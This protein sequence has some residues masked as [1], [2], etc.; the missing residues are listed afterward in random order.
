MKYFE[1]FEQVTSLKIVDS[2]FER[3]EGKNTLYVIGRTLAQ[4]YDY[5]Y[6]TAIF[7]EE[8]QN[9]L[10]WTAW[11]KIEASIPV[12]TITPIHA[13]NRLFIFWVQQ[14]E[15]GKDNEKRVDATINYIFQ[16]PSGS[17]TAPQKLASDIRVDQVNEAKKLYWK[18]VAAFYL[19]EQGGKE[20]RI[21]YMYQK[22]KVCFDSFFTKVVSVGNKTIFFSGRD[23]A[24]IDIYDDKEKVWTAYA[25]SE[26]R[27]AA[28][29]AVV[30]RKAIFFG[31]VNG[32]HPNPYSS[33]VDIYDDGAIGEKWST[34]AAS[35]ARSS[36]AI[37][38][39]GKKAIFFGGERKRE[40]GPSSKIDIYDAET[41]N[42]IT[43]TASE[44]RSYAAI[45]VVDK[46][47]IFFGGS[48]QDGFSSKIDIYDDKADVNSNLLSYDATGSDGKLSLRETKNIFETNA[49]NK[50]S[51]AEF[52]YIS[53]TSEQLTLLEDFKTS[54]AQQVMNKPGWFII[55]GNQEH[56]NIRESFLLLPKDNDLPMISE[57][58]AYKVISDKIEF[59]YVGRP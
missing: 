10:Y 51:S 2:C 53:K 43:H 25:T 46:K 12:E 17:W 20:R 41:G 13:F 59:G 1:D 9:I 28:S 22:T 7:D 5:Y 19:K 54:L 6:C 57:Q 49:T 32:L 16:K 27:S 15:K 55:E 26:S 4:P 34:H 8:N 29:K 38:V 48:T 42:W 56:E 39:V 40:S 23:D 47:A 45:A 50:E 31:G 3:V 33:K 37:A 52:L 14:I 35:E 21:E 24:K 44:A 30:G 11:E 18:K 58:S 36:P